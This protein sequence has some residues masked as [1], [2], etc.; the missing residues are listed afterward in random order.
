MP[1]NLYYRKESL[2]LEQA[3]LLRH[4][5]AKPEATT[6]FR[7]VSSLEAEQQFE[8]MEA[9]AEAEKYPAFGDKAADAVSK[10]R[11][12]RNCLD[13]IKE[14]AIKDNP[15]TIKPLIANDN[16]IK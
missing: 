7:V 3:Q 6:F 12:Y 13:V 16:S 2:P 15:Y 11:R 5:L 4:W 8:A 10:A 9:I 1:L 14:V